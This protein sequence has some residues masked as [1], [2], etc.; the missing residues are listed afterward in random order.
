MLSADQDI[1][2]AF[3]ERNIPIAFSTDANY[4]PY[5][6]VAINSIVENM[7][8]GYADILVLHDGIPQAKRSAF[9]AGFEKK[10]N[11]SVRFVGVEDAVAST[12]LS[13][14]RQKRYLS[15]AACY[16]LLLPDMLV[17][18]DKIIYL[19][20]DTVVCEDLG[21]LYE[22]DLGDSFFGAAL[23]IVNSSGNREY[24][25]WARGYG[26]EEWDEYVNTGV[27][28]FNLREFRKAS[29][30]DKLIPIAMDASNWFCD[31]DALNFV[32]KGRIKRLDPRWNVQVGDY[33]IR[34]QT[35]ITGDE[36]YVYHF[37]GGRKPWSNPE[38]MMAHHWW[39]HAGN[40]GSRLW[41]AAF[42]IDG[43]TALGDGLAVS[44][45]IPVYNAAPYLSE[46]LVSLSAQ[47]LRNIEIICVDDGSTDG[48][49]AILSEF[50]ARDSRIKVITQKNSGGAIARNRGIEEA[51]GRWHFFADADDFCRPEMLAEM[52]AKGEA[53]A[54]DVVVAG[55][56][57]IN[58]SQFGYCREM[59]IPA[60]Y[61]R[62]EQP[63]NCHTDGIN[64]FYGMGFAPWN[65]LY[66]RDFVLQGG[67]RFHQIMSCDDV[68]FV[69]VALLTAERI[70]FVGG[71]Y[72][73]YRTFIATSQ[74]GQAE[75]TPTNFLTGLREVRDVV[76]TYDSKIQREFFP[77]AVAT[78]FEN[79]TLRKTSEAREK[80][81]VA[82]RDG[83]LES[84]RLPF[85]D[86]TNVDLGLSDKAYR[87][88][89][90]GADLVDVLS[91]Y[92]TAHRMAAE[93]RFAAAEARS[94]K[95]EAW[96][97]DKVERYN[98][99]AENLK[100]YKESYRQGTSKFK[101]KLAVAEAAIAKRDR[102]LEER[103]AKLAASQESVVRLKATYQQGASK[104][105][106][107]LAVA[108]AAI[109]KRD[110]LL[111]ERTAKLAASQ[112][113]VVRL[114]ETYQQGTSKLKGRLAVAEARSGKLEA[115]LKDKTAKYATVD[116]MLKEYKETY[117]HDVAMLKERLAATE[118]ELARYART[119]RAISKTVG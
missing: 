86:E 87:L 77:V 26:F 30:L 113:S 16:R 78:C 83:G 112:E 19:D 116:K 50:A 85:A 46:M 73:Y 54:A 118:A 81:F 18:Y 114:K 68:Y 35:A 6:A 44:V 80:I 47:T 105:K 15:V 21:V 27:I 61:F 79:L 111:E 117:R 14:F 98:A 41:Q 8:S 25:A 31:Q 28:V 66:R 7:E 36:A 63:V 101:E 106:E 69:L 4:L 82:I 59:R 76:A 2:P 22:T 34:Q 89:M 96:L 115:W 74:I 20:V 42:S 24:A 11:V 108:E 1:K 58:C 48:S 23:G 51:K 12:G 71:L 5:V 104:L 75:K 72:Y 84:L 60:S 32:C 102:L 94:D 109:A 91:A 97:R 3:A 40:D 53:T 29:L 52:L 110:R 62:H 33:C 13:G 37:T 56:R 99:V 119:L 95:L 64:V 70:V 65:K 10:E 38:H 90:S 39:R 57:T 45:I 67:I 100:E 43:E 103:T 55:R 17:A 88:L 93:Q 92:Y 49:A 9:L 107:R